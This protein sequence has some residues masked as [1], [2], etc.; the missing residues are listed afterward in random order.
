MCFFDISTHFPQT[1]SCKSGN[2]TTDQHFSTHT[3]FSQSVSLIRAQMDR[4]HRSHLW[5]IDERTSPTAIEKV[6]MWARTDNNQEWWIFW[7][8]MSKVW[9]RRNTFI[10]FMCNSTL[11][12]FWLATCTTFQFVRLL[13]GSITSS[14]LGKAGHYWNCFMSDGSVRSTDCLGAQNQPSSKPAAGQTAGHAQPMIHRVTKYIIALINWE[15][16]KKQKV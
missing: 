6:S 15:T 7:S 9:S 2:P 8:T 12:V 14:A 11:T 3:S 1:K 4:N 10:C 16:S 13:L 5:G